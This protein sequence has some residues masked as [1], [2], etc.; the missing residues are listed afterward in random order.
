NLE[1]DVFYDVSK[2]AIVPMGFCFPGQ[3]SR[4]SDLPPRR[5]CRHHWHDS[6]FENMSQ[7]ELILVIGQY[8]MSY[9]LKDRMKANLTDTVG[10]WREYWYEGR[11]EWQP[12]VMPMPHPS[13]RNN[14]WL[15]KNSWFE[16][17]VLPVLRQEIAR[18]I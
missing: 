8:A 9:H 18:L 11:D 10:A 14:S 13:W 4:G 16:A 7:I 3:D 15:K 1:E 6:L 5:E 2:V 17:D 12:R